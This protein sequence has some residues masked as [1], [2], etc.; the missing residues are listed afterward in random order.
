MDKQQKIVSMFDNIAKSYDIANRILSFGVDKNWRKKGINLALSTYQKEDIDLI[1]DVAC[2]TG[3]MM[4]FWEKEARKLEIEV[5]HILGI[6][7]SVGMVDVGKKKFPQF[8]FKIASATEMGL[9]SDSADII[10][11]AYGIRNVVERE[12]AF[13]EF[14]KTL[15][16]GGLV[17]ILEFTKDRKRGLV[18][19]SRDFYMNKILPILG[20]MISGNREAY[21]YL[22]NSIGDFVSS[23][24]MVAEL[25]SVGFETIHNL[26]FS[27]GVS[28]L[29]IAR[30]G[31]SDV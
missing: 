1:V 23:E 4:G 18:S 20:G 27:M 21:T 8:E 19:R 17:V 9:E 11:I 12:K 30:K 24:E 25:E 3:D 7:P 16:S 14:F 26:S 5:A 29:I 15:K 13:V 2:G 22:P 31:V 28:S 6:D 10:S